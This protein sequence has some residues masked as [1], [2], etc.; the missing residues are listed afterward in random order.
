LAAGHEEVIRAAYRG[1]GRSEGPT[2]D[3]I[4]IAEGL[5]WTDPR[6]ELLLPFR[7]RAYINDHADRIDAEARQ[8]LLAE[9]AVEVGRETVLRVDTEHAA[10]EV[11][12]RLRSRAPDQDW[13]V[14]RQTTAS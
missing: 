6:V 11:V 3:R 9:G 10:R 4:V 1:G 7:I 2:E 5:D 12:R 13:W 8:A 14:D